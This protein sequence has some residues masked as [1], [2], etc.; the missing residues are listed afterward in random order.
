MMILDVDTTNRERRE[1]MA[2]NP[3]GKTRKVGNPYEVWKSPDGT[4]KWEVLK[5]YQ[6]D[7]NKPFGRWFC[8]VTSP[9]CPDGEYGD[10]YVGDV[11]GGR[12]NTRNVRVNI[13]VV[14]DVRAFIDGKPSSF[15]GSPS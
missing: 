6:V 2:K 3:C 7:D 9:Y 1:P 8:F 4:W 12:G 14:D 5:K 13:S 15:V 11:K 10:V